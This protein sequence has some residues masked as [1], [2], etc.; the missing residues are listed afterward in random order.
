L[1]VWLIDAS[2]IQ[3]LEGMKIKKSD[4]IITENYLPPPPGIILTM[5]E[6]ILIRFP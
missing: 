3:L 6:S 4:F 5:P 1:F 2:A